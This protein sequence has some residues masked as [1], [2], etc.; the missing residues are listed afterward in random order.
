MNSFGSVNV[1]TGPV[2]LKLNSGWVGVASGNRY[3]KKTRRTPEKAV[4]DAI[5]LD[6]KVTT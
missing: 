4:Q 2:A 5:K 1:I 6:K 3:S